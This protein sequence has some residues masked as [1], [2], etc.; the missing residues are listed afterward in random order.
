MPLRDY[1]SCDIWSSQPYLM[2]FFFFFFFSFFSFDRVFLSFL[3]P[4]EAHSQYSIITLSHASWYNRNLGILDI[5]CSSICFYLLY[6]K[7]H[8]LWILDLPSILIVKQGARFRQLSVHIFLHNGL[9]IDG[10]AIVCW[11]ILVWSFNRGNRS[12][13]N[14][15]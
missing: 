1:F 3:F 8:Y 2:L 7:F 9:V 13:L 14:Y 10:W 6:L 5:F 4:L 12:W 11:E 15:M